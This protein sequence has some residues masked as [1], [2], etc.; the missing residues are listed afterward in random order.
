MRNTLISFVICILQTL[1][2]LDLSIVRWC[3]PWFVSRI[4]HVQHRWVM[5]RKNPIREV[6]VK[7]FVPTLNKVYWVG[8]LS[9]SSSRMEVQIIF[10]IIRQ[11]SAVDSTVH[12]VWNIELQAQCE[13]IEKTSSI[14]PSNC[15]KFINSFL[16]SRL[17]NVNVLFFKSS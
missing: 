9:T 6:T 11:R 14:F 16:I 4:S 13:E 12:N 1:C 17:M 15:I 5:W 2:P 7:Q 10:K 3:Q 8:L